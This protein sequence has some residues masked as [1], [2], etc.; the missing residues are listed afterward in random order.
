MFDFL[1][2]PPGGFCGL[3]YLLAARLDLAPA[4]L[5]AALPLLRAGLA[6]PDDDV[7]AACADALVPVAGSLG[8]AGPQVGGHGG[9]DVCVWVWR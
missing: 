9:A 5:P 8:V 4:L 1:D 3:K 2:S 6:D 7:R